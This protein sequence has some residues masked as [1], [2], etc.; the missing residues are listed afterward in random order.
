MSEETY[1]FV[2]AANRLPVDRVT[3]DDGQDEW[4]RSP[5]GLVTAMA[6][7]TGLAIARS[8]HLGLEV[9]LHREH[10]RSPLHIVQH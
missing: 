9:D 4:R 8:A 2:I 3:G 1:S 7:L 5:G 10:G 6:L